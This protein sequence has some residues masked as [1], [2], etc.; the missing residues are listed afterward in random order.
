VAT[1]VDLF[2]F[3]RAPQHLDENVVDPFA[4]A[5]HADRD[6]VL[7]QDAGELSTR[8]LPP[9]TA[10]EDRWR[11]VFGDRFFKCFDAELRRHAD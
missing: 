9:L 11:S 7:R 10:V 1:Q 6:V 3:R 4:F 8:E 5:V 2:L